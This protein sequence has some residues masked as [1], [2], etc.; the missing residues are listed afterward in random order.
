MAFVWKISCNYLK[1]A[2]LS[3]GDNFW[4]ILEISVTYATAEYAKLFAECNT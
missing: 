1:A 2:L 3:A 4:G